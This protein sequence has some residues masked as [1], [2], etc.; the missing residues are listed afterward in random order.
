[1]I[2]IF[3]YL[4]NNIKNWREP[5]KR[6]FYQITAVIVLI[7][8]IIGFGSIPAAA[9][10]TSQAAKDLGCTTGKIETTT[11]TLLSAS[12]IA[13]G[14]SV[15]DTATV[16][17]ASSKPLTGTVTFQVSTDGG[18]TFSDFSGPILLSNRKAVSDPYTPAAAGTYYFRAVYSGDTNFKTSQSGKKEEKLIVGGVTQKLITTTTTTRLSSCYITLGQ[19]VTDKA[20]VSAKYSKTSLTGTVTF[21]VSTDGGVTFSDYS[22]PA[23]LSNR[24]ATSDPYTPASAGT[25][26]F[27]ALYSGDTNFEASQSGDKEEP[28]FVKAK[29][30][31]AT[32]TTTRLSAFSIYLGQ[33][34]TDTAFVNAKYAKND[35]TGMV[36][37]QVSTD[38]GVN[39][40]DYGSAKELSERKATSDSYT[41]TKA[42]LYY[43]RA[44]YS[45]DDN[46]KASQSCTK[47]EPLFVKTR[48]QITTTTTTLLSDD[49]IAPGESVTD[50]ATLSGK[51]AKC[52]VPTGTLVFQVKTPSVDFTTYDTQTVT[53][54]G[55]YTSIF[56]P[57]LTE[58]GTYYF[59]AIYSGD[60]NYVGS[61]SADDEEPL[62]VIKITQPKDESAT[63]TVLS[64]KEMTLGNGLVTDLAEVKGTLNG[65]V[66]TGSVTFLVS[67]D[68]G[69]NF[70]QYGEIKGLDENGKAISDEYEPKEV[71]TYYF[72][73]I[74]SG[75]DNY[76]PSESKPLDEPLVVNKL[77]ST[78]TTVLSTKEMTVGNGTVT[79]LATVE[80][81]LK[82]TTPGGTVTF[83]V[84]TDG[85]VTFTQYG[86]IKDLNK[87]GE[88][89]SDEYEP[90]EV[91][92]Y[93]FKAIYSGDDNYLPSE[94]GPQDEP[95]V[96]KCPF[97]LP[98]G[99]FI[100]EIVAAFPG[101]T[102]YFD[103]TLSNVPAG[104]SIGNAT[105]SA[106]CADE[107]NA[108]TKVSYQA[109][110]YSSLYFPPTTPETIT[111]I[112][113]DKINYIINHYSAGSSELNKKLDIQM[114]IWYFTNDEYADYT[115]WSGKINNPT[116]IGIITSIVTDAETNGNGFIP[117]PDQWV[118]VVLDPEPVSETNP[119][120]LTFIEVKYICP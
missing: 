63:T 88:A 99:T 96:V 47:A 108:M 37:F 83:L 91:K 51:T 36:T 109:L 117:G 29:Q 101:S 92:T 85:G 19:N 41:P 72:K 3:K 40:V 8:M 73:A 77:S 42:G 75:D 10:S 116:D 113:W 35:I 49:S 89:T 43:F 30:K 22:G 94:S 44:M 9:S 110:A 100:T 95:L 60:A 93:Y 54:Y 55:A 118:A 90:K 53:G 28:L 16:T 38:G 97:V 5:L 27:R 6:I 52:A 79:D 58:E 104:Y 65:P 66:P 69:N 13:L 45:G 24:T 11:T 14:Q 50:T 61:Q 23:S 86:A 62:T 56:C 68:G 114:A 48:Q 7:T 82:G 2:R 111:D 20:Y 67:T 119:G 70:I 120:Q 105:Y 26:Y 64:T 107:S 112:P 25:Y 4:T 98:L 57:P 21:Q 74:Y 102:S 15:T 103:I 33:S 18:V 76:L 106:W 80:E 31:L 12:T 39:F 84:S 46:F 115:R 1:V 71:K 17:A 87:K 59:R 34:V 78:I 81:T 32:T